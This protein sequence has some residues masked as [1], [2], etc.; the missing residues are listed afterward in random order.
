[1]RVLE[2]SR[3]NRPHLNINNFTGSGADGGIAAA[4]LPHA[5]S[6]CLLRDPSRD[7][8]KS[9]CL[10][11]MNILLVMR[12]PDDV[13]DPHVKFLAAIFFFLG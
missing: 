6:Q 2:Q 8:G 1:M 4:M 11:T 10:L 7:I 13:K 9:R 12:S 3:R 5:R